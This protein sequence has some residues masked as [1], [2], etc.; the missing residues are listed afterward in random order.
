MGPIGNSVGFLKL[1]NIAD[2]GGQFPVGYIG[3]RRHIPVR[4]V[5]AFDALPYRQK[6]RPIRVVAW[7]IYVVN[8]G[9]PFLSA[10]RVSAVTRCTIGVKCHLTLIGQGG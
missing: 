10:G 3:L 8:E 7:I 2:N 9:R 1:P 6:E 4:P 5:M